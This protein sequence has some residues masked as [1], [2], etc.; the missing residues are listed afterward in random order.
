MNG[1]SKTDGRKDEPEE[2]TQPGAPATARKLVPPARQQ[3]LTMPGLV[4]IAIYMLWLAAFIVYGVVRG[5]IQ[6]V[7]LVV[8]ALFI[9]A[10]FGLTLFLRWAWALALAAVLL[11]LSLFFYRF[12]IHHEPASLVQGLLNLL[13]FLYLVRTE[14][15]SKLR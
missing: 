15:R 7:Y 5:N 14:V 6:A 4:A 9:A 3:V 13:F 10:S 12:S 2:S 1:E 8:S 11:L